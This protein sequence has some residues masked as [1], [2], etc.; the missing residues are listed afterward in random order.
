MSA[1]L[2]F[3]FG[4]FG[5]IV[6][7][8]PWHF[9]DM[10][11]RMTLSYPTMRDAEI[12][13]LNVDTLAAERGHLFCW[14]TDSHLEL[15]LACIRKWGFVF[16]SIIH[17]IKVLDYPSTLRKRILDASFDQKLNGRA[18]EDA[19]RRIG[20]V[21][22]G[23]GHFTRNAAESCLFATRNLTGLVRDIPNVIMAPHPRGAN[24]K[25]IH[26]AKPPELHRIAE[27]LSPGPRIELFARRSPGPQW[28]VWGN[29]A[30]TEVAA[31]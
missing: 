23:G 13:A 7:D 11:N 1:P 30:P 27:R 9:D 28:T 26:S 12:L 17:W 25:I 10:A 19:V 4:G 21:K 8:P 3:R 20:K 6:I 15:A 14:T 5:C 22:I 31:S 29:Q 16:K 24:G 18:L 2:P